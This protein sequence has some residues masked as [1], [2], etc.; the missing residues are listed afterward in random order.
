[1]RAW[2]ERYRK[3]GL[4][5]IGVHAPE[6]AFERDPANVE[7]AVRDLKIRYPVA[8][9]NRY[10]LWRALKNNVWPAHYFID[11]QGRVRYHHFGEGDYQQSERVI[12][13]LLAE[14][15]RAPKTAALATA[16]KSATE[17]SANFAEIKSPETYIGYG[18]AA[19]FVSPGGLLRDRVKDYSA[20]PLELNQWA[21]EGRW[22]DSRQ[23][24]RS[25]SAGA[26]I[27]FRFKAR[28]LH[29]VLGS[30]TGRP[31]PFTVTIDG[32]APGADAGVDIDAS[33]AG[34][35]RGQRLYQLV[36]Q[37]AGAAE[38]TFTITFADP[39]VEAFAF[40]FG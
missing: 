9:D 33:G 21:L 19:N 8:L 23:S 11:A 37:K 22:L 7:R 18:R 13:Q 38:R 5:V 25:L 1:V 39:G 28:D 31:I 3:D 36:R 12:R 29:L 2:D 4:V 10:D 20:A 14:A 32:R 16:T 17:Q 15:G 35:V 6:F 26:A 34:V 40:T 24:A 30:A 27:S